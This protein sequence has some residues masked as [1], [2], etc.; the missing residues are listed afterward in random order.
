MSNNIQPLPRYPQPVLQPKRIRPLVEIGLKLKRLG[1]DPIKTLGAKNKM[2]KGWPTMANDEAS[3]R[4]WKGL[5]V[6]I[7]MY[8]SELI[9]IDID[10]RTT[11][12]RDLILDW[13]TERWPEFMAC[14]LRRVS[15]STTIALFGQMSKPPYKHLQTRRYKAGEGVKPHLVEAFTGLSKGHF[16]VYGPHSAG[17]EYSFIGRAMWEVPRWELPLF[18]GEDME[19]LVDGIERLMEAQGLERVEGLLT[20]IA[21]AIVYDLEP[22]TMITRGNGEVMT[23]IELEKIVGFGRIECFPP[24][25]PKSTTPRVL[26]NDSSTGLALYDTKFETSHRWAWQKPPESFEEIQA[27]LRALLNRNDGGAK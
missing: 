19:A 9:A 10:V 21:P 25:H 8:R 24:W 2:F 22:G 20:A 5:G 4:G 16:A 12:L 26:A 15:G 27:A 11:E 13:I 14:C 6:G 17:R 1:Y 7:R 3:I 18:P 23:L